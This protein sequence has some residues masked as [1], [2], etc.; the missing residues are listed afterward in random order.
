MIFILKN[1]WQIL[2]SFQINLLIT[3]LSN[4]IHPCIIYIYIS[5]FA[6]YK[7][8]STIPLS[9]FIN[10]SLQFSSQISQLV[11]TFFNSFLLLPGIRTGP[12]EE[13]IGSSWLSFIPLV[14]VM[15]GEPSKYDEFIE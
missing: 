7:T 9:L 10:T 13:P 8:E 3:P 2:K 11:N 6:L 4:S 12:Q 15:F 5:H 1:V 14:M